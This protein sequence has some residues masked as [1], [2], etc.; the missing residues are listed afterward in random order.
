[1][2]DLTNVFKFIYDLF[3]DDCSFY[4]ELTLILATALKV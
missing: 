2:F 4:I 3:H 1:M